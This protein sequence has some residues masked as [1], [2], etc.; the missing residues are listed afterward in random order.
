MLVPCSHLRWFEP[1]VELRLQLG[2]L[3][4]CAAN[5]IRGVCGRPGRLV[6]S[7]Y[8]SATTMPRDGYDQIPAPAVEKPRSIQDQLDDDFA[9]DPTELWFWDVRGYLVL[10]GV[11][12][13]AWLTAANEAI[14][15]AIAAQPDLPAGHL[16]VV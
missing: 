14:D 2:D 16:H 8:I 6:E 9:P 4:I 10:R 11:M 15:Y 12:D 13:E 3:L 1:P 7:Q 5:T